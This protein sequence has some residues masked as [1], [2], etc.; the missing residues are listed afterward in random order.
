MV[1]KDTPSGVKEMLFML[2]G[3]PYV[4]LQD[5]L[6][7]PP[8]TVWVVYGPP[9]PPKVAKEANRNVGPSHYSQPIFIG[10]SL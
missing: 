7:D 9:A 1:T 10:R 3:L 8:K 2:A 5:R 4:R 6:Q